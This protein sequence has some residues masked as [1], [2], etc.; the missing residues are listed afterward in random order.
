MKKLLLFVCLFTRLTTISAEENETKSPK[1]AGSILSVLLEHVNLSGYGQTGY[2]YNSYDPVSQKSSNTFDIKRI[3]FVANADIT[4][5]LSLAF[6]YDF[7]T[8]MLHEY[9]GEYRFCDA[10]QI[11]V[12]QFK[13]PFTIESGLSPSNLEIISGAQSVQYLAGIDPSDICYGG[14]AGRDL[15]IMASGNFI[16]YKT[17]KLMEYKLGV[18]NGQGPNKRDKNRYKDVVG[19]LTLQPLKD[20]SLVGSFYL[21]HGN[22]LVDN[23]FGA[24]RAGDNYERNRWSIGTEVKTSPVYVRAEYMEGKDAI[25]KSRGAYAVAS[26]HVHPK[27]DVIA[28]YDYFDQNTAVNSRQTNYIVGAQWNFFRRC[29]LQA[30]YVYQDRGTDNKSSNLI[31]TQIQL[32]F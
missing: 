12:G 25:I 22:S 19:M 28:S 18:F 5:N 8:A 24:F 29:R 27:W 23:T 32:G 13:T 2:T 21:G 7:S 30:Q 16:P 20:I 31:M 14:N 9:W 11:K 3:I 15:G 1:T 26:I 17:W 4:K 6:M 10:F